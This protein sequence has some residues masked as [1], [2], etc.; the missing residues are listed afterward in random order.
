MKNK[1]LIIDDEVLIVE[2]VEKYLKSK[3][4]DTSTAFSGKEGLAKAKK[5][6]PDLTLLDVRMPEINGLTICKQ[7]RED[8]LT[9]SL[10]VIMLSAKI[11][12]E[13]KLNGIKAGADDYITKPFDLQELL[14]RIKRILCYTSIKKESNPLT[15]LP[16]KTSIEYEL[17]RKIN[18]NLKYAVCYLGLNNF[19][20]YNEKYGYEKG[21]NIICQLAKIIN[22]SISRKGNF[23]D[24]VS[25]IGGDKFVIL[26]TSQKADD[27]CSSII[28]DF[29]ESISS[30]Y[31]PEDKK[32]GSIE[33]L[34]RQGIKL[35]FPFL[36]VAIGVITNHC[37]KFTNPIEIL[38]TAKEM[39]NYAQT[40][41]IS[42]Y[43]KK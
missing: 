20:S 40:F 14:V 12:Y 17:N 24:F 23:D 38:S 33:N 8:R 28:K 2:F 36:F 5:E 41:N 25:H 15:G 11:S 35:Q 3:G 30:F 32:Q 34:N 10:P 9:H 31:A 21:D 42:N 6:L 7:L 16:G 43:K 4:F 39:K 27:I 26:T 22:K 19:K 29:N 1:I 37:L 13:D 18:K